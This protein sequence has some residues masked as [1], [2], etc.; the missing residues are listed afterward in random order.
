M[1]TAEVVRTFIESAAVDLDRDRELLHYAAGCARR[2]VHDYEWAGR[3]AHAVL[4]HAHAMQHQF[5]G[6]DDP[7]T[8]KS[9]LGRIASNEAIDQH[10]AEQRGALPVMEYIDNIP[11]PS[12]DPWERLHQLL[13]LDIV[14]RQIRGAPDVLSE[15]EQNCLGCAAYL[16]MPPLVIAEQLSA[17][18]RITTRKSVEN[19]ICNARKK[20]RALIV[21]E[22]LR[23]PGEKILVPS[24]AGFKESGCHQKLSLLFR[25]ED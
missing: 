18:G 21:R 9:W 19:A 1:I 5:N 25:E 14:E 6:G 11:A 22:G 8:F 2:I 17:S 7:S 16:D 13:I 3:I 23:K 10:R 15:L 4:L 12:H 24:I 20:L